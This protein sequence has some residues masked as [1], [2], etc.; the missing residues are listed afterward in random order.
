MATP[1]LFSKEIPVLL[2]LRKSLTWNKHEEPSQ[3]IKDWLPFPKKLL[4]PIHLKDGK[5]QLG[6]ELELP[7]FS[8]RP[9]LLIFSQNLDTEETQ[10]QSILANQTFDFAP[11]SLSLPNGDL[12]LSF[13]W[14]YFS[15]GDPERN[16]MKIGE[17]NLGK[18]LEFRV[19]GKRDFSMTGRR[20][21]TYLE[22]TIWIQHL[23]SL[24]QIEKVK[25][26]HFPFL[27]PESDKLVD[28]R[29]LLW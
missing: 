11:L 10:I 28:L 17:I 13:S 19:N 24:T 16:A 3:A 27:L 4:L 2:I 14:D 8:Q 7:D 20:D 1:L 9:N 21:R 29:K 5:L 12:V 6:K 23:G 18:C 22:Q 15:V 26:K 25:N